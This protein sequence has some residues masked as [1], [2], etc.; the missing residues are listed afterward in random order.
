MGGFID[1]FFAN[2]LW[3]IGFVLAFVA[4]LSFLVF[5][6]GFLSGLPNLFTLSAHEGHQRRHRVR[7]TWGVILL[8]FLYI[9]WE[10]LRW[11]VGWL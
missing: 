10:I 8:I 1:S 4:A 5:L 9:I 7:I 6:R 2:P 11:L 3:Y